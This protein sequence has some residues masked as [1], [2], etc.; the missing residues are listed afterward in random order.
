MAI[1][2]HM[3]MWSHSGKIKFP[4]FRRNKTSCIPLKTPYFANYDDVT[5]VSWRCV[6]FI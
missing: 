5:L 2:R 3:A 4:K 1:D 6:Y